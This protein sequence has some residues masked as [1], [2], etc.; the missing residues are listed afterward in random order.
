MKKEVALFPFLLISCYVFFGFINE[1]PAETYKVICNTSCDSTI[2]YFKEQIMPIVQEN[3][4]SCHNPLNK[5]DDISLVNFE[6]IKATIGIEKAIDFNKNV[7]TKVILRDKMPPNPHTKLTQ[8][9]KK[10]I[11]KWIEQGMLNNSCESTIEI[12]K[13][14]E[15]TFKKDINPMLQNNCVGCH[16]Q[17]NPAAGI[18]LTDYFMII[19][20]TQNGKIFKTISHADGVVAMPLNAQKLLDSEIEMFATWEKT[21]KN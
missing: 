20:L 10:L 16:N 5:K 3:C 4:V 2:V 11:L 21:G 7:F 14:T 12:Q 17:S 8:N 6:N 19:E 9:Q 13:P 18:D 15:I 1:N